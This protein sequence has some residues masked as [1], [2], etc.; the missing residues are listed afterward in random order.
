MRPRHTP[1]SA[2][3]EDAYRTFPVNVTPSPTP[4]AA[5]AVTG[6]SIVNI[7]VCDRLLTDESAL[8]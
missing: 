7:K 4:S 3:E 1:G 6:L 8:C 2:L 5:D